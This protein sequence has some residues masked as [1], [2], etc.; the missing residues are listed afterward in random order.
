MTAFFSGGRARELDSLERLY[1]SGEFA[2]AVV[3][4]R[5]R[6]GKTSLIGEFIRRGNKKAICFTATES[7]DTANLES[8]S[9]CVL[10]AYPELSSL[11]CF[12]TWESAFEYIA[13]QAKGE[14]LVLEID[15]YQPHHAYRKRLRAS[16][17]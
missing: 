7:T 1:S 8:F 11:N 13:A 15:E 14:K 9:R 2:L 17:L 4:G 5:R 10:A 16:L 6:V 12:P 3:Y